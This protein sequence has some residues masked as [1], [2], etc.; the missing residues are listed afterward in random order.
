MAPADFFVFRGSDQTTGRWHVP[1]R[2]AAQRWWPTIQ[3][4]RADLED[5][6]AWFEHTAQI[7]DVRILRQAPGLGQAGLF[8]Q[9]DRGIY[10]ADEVFEHRALYGWVL[11]HEMGHALDPRFE[12]FGAVEYGQPGHSHRT[13]DY[14][15]IAEAA[16]AVA[17]GSF[18]V[19]LPP[20]N[21]YLVDTA[22]DKWRKR[23]ENPEIAGRLSVV[24]GILRKPPSQHTRKQQREY[25]RTQE[26]LQAAIRRAD[27]RIQQETAVNNFM[28]KPFSRKAILDL[29]R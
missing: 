23:L 8:S 4:S 2:L 10:L 7:T 3:G 29:W 26:R 19:I 12:A 11:A 17:C 5:A 28:Q 14:E 22:G 21:Y 16:A 24:S 9:A 20:E 13:R 18:G 25:R 6:I 1:S 15:L 27:K